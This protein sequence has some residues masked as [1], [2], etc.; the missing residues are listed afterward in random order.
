MKNKHKFA[1]RHSLTSV[2]PCFHPTIPPSICHPQKKT[3]LFYE[4]G[5]LINETREV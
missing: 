1:E 2:I 4:I 3:K 5:N